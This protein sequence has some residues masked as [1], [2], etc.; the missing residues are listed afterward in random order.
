MRRSTI[1]VV[2]TLL[3]S[4]AVVVA[5]APK[6]PAPARG[7]PAPEHVTAEVRQRVKARMGQHGITMQNLVRAVVLLDRPT[8]RMLANRIADE[9]IIA[10]ATDLREKQPPIL[11]ARFFAEQDQLA[12]AAR[13]LAAAAVDGGEDAALGDRFAAVT[14]TCVACHSTYLHDS[15]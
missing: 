6:T 14:R 9:E 7:L 12:A 3:L 10:R 2:V 5:A 1:A 4:V 11:P 13:E 15:P 8:V